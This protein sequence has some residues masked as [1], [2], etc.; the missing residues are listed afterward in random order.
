MEWNVLYKLNSH[1]HCKYR[2]RLE[3]QKCLNSLKKG[4]VNFTLTLCFTSSLRVKI[5][6]V[7][8]CWAH[9][10]EICLPYALF[11]C[12]DLFHNYQSKAKRFR[13]LMQFS[14]QEHIS[15]SMLVLLFGSHCYCFT[16]ISHCNL[17]SLE[18]KASRLHRPHIVFYL[19]ITP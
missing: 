5:F 14:H 9:T 13:F 15:Q 17:R 10:W 16:P 3:T 4:E 6:S 11:W 19:S 7:I 8:Y 2:S 18:R 1:C 12:L